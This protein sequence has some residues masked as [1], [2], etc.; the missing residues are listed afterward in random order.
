MGCPMSVQ[1]GYWE[2]GSSEQGHACSDNPPSLEG[3]LPGSKVFSDCGLAVACDGLTPVTGETTPGQPPIF[4]L[5]DGRLDNRNEIVS[6]LDG[7][8]SS[9]GG[10]HQIVAAADSR[11]QP[12]S[13]RTLTGECSLS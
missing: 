2:F 7:R 4:L 11:S 13:L 6:E 12:A 1:L 8:V 3:R 5:W 9:A 10:D